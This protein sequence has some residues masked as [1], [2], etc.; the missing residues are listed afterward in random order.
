MLYSLYRVFLF[1]AVQYLRSPLLTPMWSVRTELRA[2]YVTTRSRNVSY[3]MARENEWQSIPDAR[4]L[5]QNLALPEVIYAPGRA[6]H[7]Q[8]H[9]Y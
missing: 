2:D 6:F 1:T 8:N 9:H 3:L 4:V 7:F 5:L